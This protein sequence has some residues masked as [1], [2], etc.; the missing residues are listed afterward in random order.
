M[1]VSNEPRISAAVG[2][3]ADRPQEEALHTAALADRF[4]YPELWIGEAGGFDVF[5]LATAIGLATSSIALTIGPVPVPVRD[6]ATIATGAGTVAALT[7]RTVDMALGAAPA[8]VLDRH[9]RPGAAASTEL[10]AVAAALPGLLRGDPGGSGLH[11]R[12]SPAPAVLTIAAL[13]PVAVGAAA[14]HAERMVAGP[15]DVT[16][17]GR[18]AGELAAAARRAGRSTPRLAVWLPAAVEPGPETLAQLLAALAARIPE[19]GYARLYC[20]AGYAETVAA[21]DARTPAHELLAALPIAAIEKFALVGGEAAIRERIAA[22][23]DAG[24]DEIVVVPA[25]AGDPGGE[26]TLRT[27]APA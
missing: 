13:G 3:W 4:G 7:R 6:P 20:D 27:L 23:A 17:A 26:R 12:P 22:Y 2:Q 21:C 24:V 1:A 11:P 25:T 18:L 14:R 9:G 5:A 19:P 8:R 15:I 10:D 16:A